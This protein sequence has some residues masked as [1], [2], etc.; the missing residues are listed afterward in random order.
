M[1][2]TT[3]VCGF[4]DKGEN[5][6][7]KWINSIQT[8][9]DEYGTPTNEVERYFYNAAYEVLS[10]GSMLLASKLPYDNDSLD[11]FAYADFQ[12]S[13]HPNRDIGSLPA[14]LKR[15]REL[16]DTISTY[17]EVSDIPYVPSNTPLPYGLIDIETFDALKTGNTASLGGINRLRIVDITQRQY[18]TANLVEEH[19][20]TSSSD[21][22]FSYSS[23]EQELLGVLPVIVTPVNALYFHGIVSDDISV[24]LDSSGKSDSGKQFSLSIEQFT[25]IADAHN[26]SS[27]HMS[28]FSKPNIIADNFTMPLSTG[29]AYDESVAK[30]ASMSFPQISFTRINQLSRKCMKHIGIAVFVVGKDKSD[31]GKLT[32]KLVES[33]SGSLDRTERDTNGSSLYISDIVNAQSR[34]INVFSNVQ[35]DSI[36]DIDIALAHA[37]DATILGYPKAACAKTASYTKSIHKALNRIF[38]KLQDVNY[39]DIDLVCD[40][41]VTNIAQYLALHDEMSCDIS[42]YPFLLNG[43]GEQQSW[44]LDCANDARGWRATV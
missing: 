39:A 41:G 34:Y 32:F 16:D 4:G 43:S 27:V 13:A 12:V 5:Y 2:T 24:M 17:F 10:R 7:T 28:T 11:K 30:I 6:T 15:I 36:K 9:E 33:F 42:H 37:Q 44:K 26:L 21:S 14:S 3:L 22:S 25:P 31:D 29:C 23:G 20:I 19:A 35:R 1:N 8:F 40:A 38:D 18:E